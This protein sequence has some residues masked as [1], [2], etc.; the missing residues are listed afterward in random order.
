MYRLGPQWR[1]LTNASYPS[2][3][4][5]CV[6]AG[7]KNNNCHNAKHA[8]KNLVLKWKSCCWKTSLSVISSM[9]FLSNLHYSSAS[10]LVHQA[11]NSKCA[12]VNVVL[13][14][15]VWNN[16]STKW[17][18]VCWTFEEEKGYFIIWRTRGLTVRSEST[19]LGWYHTQLTSA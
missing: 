11:K 1:A 13:Q 15:T 9:C 14:S 6:T 10:S 4:Y 3:Q 7:K 16:G 2:L 18:K 8:N 5:R 17:Q 12:T 19:G